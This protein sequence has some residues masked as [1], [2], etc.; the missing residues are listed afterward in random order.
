MDLKAHV[1]KGLIFEFEGEGDRVR[2]WLIDLNRFDKQDGVYLLDTAFPRP[3]GSGGR[4]VGGSGGDLDRG[5]S[6]GGRSEGERGGE[7]VG[8]RGEGIGN[9]SDRMLRERGG[10]GKE[11]ERGEEKGLGKRSREGIGEGGGSAGDDS[12]LAIGEAEKQTAKLAP[13]KTATTMTKS[14][15]KKK[16]ERNKKDAHFGDGRGD[17]Q[18]CSASGVPLSS[19]P[20]QTH[21]L[22]SSAAPQT[23]NPNS[24]SALP[25]PAPTG[26]GFSASAFYTAAQRLPAHLQQLLLTSQ[27]ME[28]LRL[29]GDSQGRAGGA[30][31]VEK[32]SGGVQGGVSGQAGGGME[33]VQGGLKV[34]VS[35]EQEGVQSAREV[36]AAVRYLV[37]RY[38]QAKGESGGSLDALFGLP[39]VRGEREEGE[40]GEGMKEGEGKKKGEGKRDGERR[41]GEEGGE[42]QGRDEGEGKEGEDGAIHESV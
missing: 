16:K 11:G 37:S 8:E 27:Q 2:V 42:G 13:T 33:G 17:G 4:K 30:D 12:C 23:L 34:R 1:G 9:T 19:A 28:A 38:E 25:Y 41:E 39:L 26:L 15:K 24:P 14:K 21:A 10:E 29:W 6:R 7:E 20:S 31:L 32:S 3:R 36:M 35:G 40:E 18:G 22:G 5:G